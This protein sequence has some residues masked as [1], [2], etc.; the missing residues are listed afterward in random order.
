MK[1]LTGDNHLISRKVCKDVGLVA[2][3]M[4]LGGDRENVRCE[5][6]EAAEKATFSRASLP[7]TKRES[8][9]C[10]GARDTWSDSWAMAST[11]PPHCAPPM[12]AS[13]WIPR[14][15]SPRNRPT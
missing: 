15:I 2:D 8:S 9:V 1:I 10:S 7:R 5:L 11:M 13:R 14:R 12:S 6:A 3:P 4:L